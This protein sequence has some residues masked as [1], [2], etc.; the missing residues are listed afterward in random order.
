MDTEAHSGQ[1]NDFGHSQWVEMGGY[2]PSQQTSPIP[3]FHGFGYGPAPIMPME[4]SYS[5]SIPPSYASLPLAMPSHPWPSMLTAHSSFH[6]GGLPPAPA[7]APISISPPAPTHPIRT[8]STGSTPRRTL[9]DEDRRRMCLYHEENKNAKQTDIGA[10][11]GVERSTVSKVLRQKEKYLNPDD[12]SRS[13][14]KR[15]KGRVPDIEKALSNWARNYQRQ[16][17][18]LTDAMIREKAHFFATTCG[19]PDGKEKVLTT[20]WLEKFKQKNNLL[21]A[22]S[23]KGS[24]DTASD[25]GSPSQLNTNSSTASASQ[26]PSGVSPISPGGLTTPSPVSPPA[27]QDSLRKDSLQGFDFGNDYRPTH[28]QST[29]SLDTAPSL[30]ASMASPTS[31]FVSDSPYTPTLQNGLPSIGSNSSRPRSQTF[32]LAAAIEP[33]LL[34][35]NGSA[36]QLT[37]KNVLQESM[38]TS[39]LDSPLDDAA[40]DSDEPTTIR[41]NHSSPEIKTQLMQPPPLPKS[42]TT[43]PISAPSSPTQDEA[44]RA[45]ELVMNY[46]QNQ[47]SGLGAHDFMTIGKLMEK[48][49]LAQ[50]QASILPG[51][52]HRIDERE[53]GLRV[54]KKRSIHSLT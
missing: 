47:P 16:G 11:F 31:P 29:T 53:D 36:D 8:T 49:E 33:G 54:S 43:S 32:P 9:T 35:P 19:S 41:R 14:I 10:L 50:N 30:T 25:I 48:L 39:V 26:T 38:S 5:M 17:Y 3:D 15:A 23:R 37:P 6:E 51:G 52:L 4:P 2:N 44:R 40:L 34:S 22:K 21:G 7:P 20:A 13:P 12:G 1:E 46:F 28:A 27:N 42:N 24:I 45:L 18:P